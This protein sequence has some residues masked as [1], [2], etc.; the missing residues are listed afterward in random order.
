MKLT[1]KSGRG[2]NGCRLEA[3]L[4]A[5]EQPDLSIIEN[6]KPLT[7]DPLLPLA[8]RAKGA[9][10]VIVYETSGL[11]SLNGF[12]RAKLSSLQFAMLAKSL[13]SAYCRCAEAGL[14]ASGLLLAPESVFV[15]THLPAL[16]FAY[17]PLKAPPAQDKTAF[18]LLDFL[19]TNASF[20]NPEDAFAKDLLLKYI[21]SNTVFMLSDFVAY[22]RE[23]GVCDK[24]DGSLRKSSQV[25]HSELDSESQIAGQEIAGQARNDGFGS[26]YT[27]CGPLLSHA[28]HVTE[29]DRPPCHTPCHTP[30]AY[31]FVAKQTGIASKQ[32]SL[33]A[34]K[35]AEQ[36]FSL[37][38]QP[39]EKGA[40]A[41]PLR[42][43]WQA[44][45]TAAA[46]ADRAAAH[47][48]VDRGTVHLSHELR[49]V[50]R[51]TGASFCVPETG[52]AA[53][54]RSESCEFTIG[55]NSNVSRRHAVVSSSGGAVFVCDAGSS[56]GSHIS[57]AGEK[58][59]LAAGEPAALLRGDVLW[60]SDEALD[61]VLP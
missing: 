27:A 5:N 61:C 46:G 14:D 15:E 2:G 16:R 36:A 23:A 28:Q 40:A 24:G 50:Q 48:E 12:L 25:R 11:M 47:L 58:I 3:R 35:P 18:D 22:L 19:A 44:D 33:A 39:T 13:Y 20:V 38:T 1:A 42:D 37:A 26:F 55:G 30:K 6:W 32:D 57:R 60:L 4:S 43:E 29:E 21:R 53:L 51:R 7:D 56:N 52:E 59:E 41:G 54:G 34:L 10:S 45:R 49:L 17:L 9:R 31:D 8:C